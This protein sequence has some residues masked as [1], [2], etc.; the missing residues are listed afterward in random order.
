MNL[1]DRTGCREWCS[2]NVGAN[3]SQELTGRTS[4]GMTDRICSIRGEIIS[5]GRVR[6]RVILECSAVSPK[7]MVSAMDSLGGREITI[8]GVNSSFHL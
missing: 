6:N 8:N 5:V 4:H 7:Q 3:Q 2:K 1:S